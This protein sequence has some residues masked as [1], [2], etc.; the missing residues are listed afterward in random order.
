MIELIIYLAILLLGL[1]LWIRGLVLTYRNKLLGRYAIV[2]V[3]IFGAYSIFWFSKSYL[4]IDHDEYG[5]RLLFGYPLLLAIHSIIVFIV[6]VATRKLA[7]A[8]EQKSHI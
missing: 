2:N 7:A 4:V 8:H 3:L 1:V 5:L 6:I